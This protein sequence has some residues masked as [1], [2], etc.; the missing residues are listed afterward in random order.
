MDGCIKLAVNGSGVD[1]GV[2]PTAT[3]SIDMAALR[4]GNALYDAELLRRM[5]ARRHPTT[6]VELGDA[7]AIGDA[8]RYQVTGA[9]TLHGIRR[10]ISGVLQVSELGGGR[11]RVVVE[12]VIDIR[13]FDIAPPSRLMLRIYPD[14]RVQ[15]QLEAEP[16]EAGF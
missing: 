5:D 9:V 13:D 3:L 15:L 2:T 6:F 10:N 14:V 1:M 7:A 16:A 11:L 4:S 12:Q 8:D